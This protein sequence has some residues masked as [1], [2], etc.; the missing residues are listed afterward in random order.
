MRVLYDPEPRA[1]EE[2]FSPEDL[3]Q[4]RGEGLAPPQEPATP[5]PV[6]MQCR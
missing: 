6:A 5:V 2:I 1:T 4:L 3:A